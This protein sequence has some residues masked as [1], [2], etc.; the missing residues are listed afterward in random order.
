MG[1]KQETP[2]TSLRCTTLLCF[3]LLVLLSLHGVALVEYIVS[4]EFSQRAMGRDNNEGTGTHEGHASQHRPT[5]HPPS[6]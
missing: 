3:V 5:T 1:H 2:L 4:L 6:E